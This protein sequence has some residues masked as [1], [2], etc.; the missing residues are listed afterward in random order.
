MHFCK[1]HRFAES[2]T[3]PNLIF[4]VPN[5]WDILNRNAAYISKEN[6]RLH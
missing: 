4:R 2:V 5:M 1:S 6:P 3:N